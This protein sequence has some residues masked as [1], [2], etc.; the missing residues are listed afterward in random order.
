MVGQLTNPPKGFEDVVKAHFY[1]KRH[2]L[3]EE[4]EKMAEKFKTAEAGGLNIC[5]NV[6]KQLAD[7]VEDLW[8]V[9][10]LIPRVPNL[11]HLTVDLLRVLAKLD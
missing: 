6:K 7:V 5:G 2:V 1:L 3:L 10:L 11:P 9:I 4:Y 8:V